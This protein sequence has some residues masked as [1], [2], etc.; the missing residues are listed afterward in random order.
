MDALIVYKWG[1][2]ACKVLLTYMMLVT[3]AHGELSEMIMKSLFI[4][5]VPT[6]SWLYYFE[7]HNN[8][9]VHIGVLNIVSWIVYFLSYYSTT[10]KKDGDDIVKKEL[11]KKIKKYNDKGIVSIPKDDI[12]L[13]YEMPISDLK[14][15][16]EA[17][18]VPEENKNKIKEGE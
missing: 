14:K 17:I 18:R 2:R 13:L 9:L 8:V 16:Y 7:H 11:I 1:Y 3:Y 5:A 6:I 12:E 10:R 15:I 4:I